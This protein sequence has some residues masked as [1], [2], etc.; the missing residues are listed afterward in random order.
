MHKFWSRKPH[1]VVA[2]YI[3]NFSSPGEIVL[4]PFG[5]SGVSLIEAERLGRRAINN[6]ASELA[7]FIAR[8]TARPGDV[9]EFTRVMGEVLSEAGERAG[10]LYHTRCPACGRTATI[11]HAIWKNEIPVQLYIQCDCKE[12]EGISNSGNSAGTKQPDEEDLAF[13]NNL[14]ASEAYLLAKH[15][16]PSLF[17]PLRYPSGTNFMQLRHGLRKDPRLAMLFTPRNLIACH[18]IFACIEAK[19]TGTGAASGGSPAIAPDITDRLRFAFTSALPQASKMVWVISKRK[20]KDVKRSEVGSWTHHFFWNPTEY[21]EVNA[22]NCLA[23]RVAKIAR[24]I[25]DTNAWAADA[26]GHA[27]WVKACLDDSRTW[28]LVRENEAGGPLQAIEEYTP[29]SHVEAADLPAFFSSPECSSAF[30]TGPAQD[31]HDIPDESID[32]I[33]TD[34]PYGDAIQYGE[35]GTFFLAWLHPWDLNGII[36]AVDEEITINQAQGKD[37]EQYRSDL[38][39]A[40]AECTRVLKPGRFMTVTFHN[41]DLRVRSIVLEALLEAGLA[42]RDI[43]YQPPAR[44]SEKSLLHEFGSPVGDYMITVQKQPATEALD[45]VGIGNSGEILTKAASSIFRARGEPVPF[46][47][48]LSLIDMELVDKG[49]MPPSDVRSLED[50]LEHD[51]RFAWTKARG[52]YLAT[53][54]EPLNGQQVPLKDR[55]AEF[56]AWIMPGLEGLPPLV[57]T[58]AMYNEIFAKFTRALTPDLRALK[59]QL[60]K[61]RSRSTTAAR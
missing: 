5:G 25:T 48:L 26:G 18:E 58:E 8:N 46:P 1:N 40:F 53:G 13:L 38:G 36:R 14:E 19:C 37:L 17:T 32:Y 42:F 59:K 3:A 16:L 54:Q 2:A 30:R 55:I 50:V 56:V 49:Y 34:P 33:F 51:S 28:W 12:T 7:T 60:G 52:W 45:L 47:H 21:F 31:L 35:L 61:T 24:G 22:I 6:D 11:T 43:T 44:P 39:R 10:W 23:E 41:T 15:A 27:R 20:G 4:D 29:L 9:T 57:G